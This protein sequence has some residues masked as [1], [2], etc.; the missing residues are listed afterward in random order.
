MLSRSA[1]TTGDAATETGFIK[2]DEKGER[3]GT[4]EEGCKG[5][6]K[7]L[8]ITSGVSPGSGFS[9]CGPA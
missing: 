1:G 3:I 8:R 9:A 5:Y 7:W 2:K 4:G 6:L